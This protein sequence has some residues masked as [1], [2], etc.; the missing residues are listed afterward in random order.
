MNNKNILR[1]LLIVVVSI[2]LIVSLAGCSMIASKLNLK[3]NNNKVEA[4][5]LPGVQPKQNSSQEI[6]ATF[7]SAVSKV[8]ED[9][10]PSVVNVKVKITQEDIFGNMQEGEGVG[11]GI[12]FTTD[13]YIITNNHVA[14]NAKSITVTLLDGKEYSAKLIGTDK[15]T[16]IAVI[17]IEAANLKPANFTTIENIKVGELAIA[18]GS[19]FG[20]QETVTQGVVSAIGRDVTVS[21]DSYP[22][23]DL[24]QTDAAINPGNSGGPLVN[25]SGQVMGVNAMIFSNSGTSSGIGF[26]IPSD[27]AL[28]IAKQ[29][30]QFGKAKTPFMGIE[31][32][33][34]TSD[35]KGVYI[36]S[37]T[38][39]NAAEKAGIKQGDI[40]TEFGAEKIETPY[41][42]LAQ[43]VRHNVGDSITLK[44][45]RDGKIIDINLILGESQ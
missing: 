1:N 6:L 45:S 40:I 20:L 15:N 43:I 18:L 44:I 13:G 30:I 42:L 39:G 21:A 34:N 33:Q 32:G 29:I 24:I 5:A 23:V 12:I 3:S 41:Q 4:S 14:G 16:D 11:S 19:P 8:A 25:S 26:A 37:V 7:D 22:M 10:K 27:T 38:K 31:M 9:V 2:F 28:N 36:K 35:V 17:K